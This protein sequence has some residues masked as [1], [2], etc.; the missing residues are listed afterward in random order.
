M[1]LLSQL[2]FFT[3]MA[4]ASGSGSTTTSA[5]ASTPSL[6]FTVKLDNIKCLPDSGEGYYEW[7]NTV[8][9]LA[10][11][12]MLGELLD[13]TSSTTPP[14]DTTELRTWKLRINQAKALLVSVVEQPLVAIITAQ[15]TAR[16]AW[17]SLQERFD[18]CN[19]TTLFFSVQ[20]FFANQQMGTDTPMIDHLNN[21]DTIHRSLVDR[22]KETETTSPY[23]HLVSYLLNDTI[24]SYHLLMTS[25][26]PQFHN[27]VDNILT[28]G[29]QTSNDVRVRL[30]KLV[31]SSIEPPNKGKALFSKNK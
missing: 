13:G 20:S 30:L 24:K 7:S 14:S 31:S 29:D 26:R 8:T 4:S 25:P 12:H 22:L 28:K 9:L 23:R 2:P 21:Y 1:D 15:P 16:E 17:T 10:S 11:V 5:P 19:G 6:P 3:E 27:V 18:R